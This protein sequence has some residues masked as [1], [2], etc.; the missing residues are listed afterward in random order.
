MKKMLLLFALM[1]LS[2]NTCAP[3]PT[4]TAI[5]TQSPTPTPTPTLT[6]KPTPIPLEEIPAVDLGL[7][8][9]L[10]SLP[11]NIE[12]EILS[13]GML[14][15]L[16]DGFAGAK[17]G[18]I[19]EMLMPAQLWQGAKIKPPL[20]QWVSYGEMRVLWR[21]EVGDEINCVT[22]VAKEDNQWGLEKG[23]ISVLFF[24][25]GENELLEESQPLPILWGVN[26]QVSLTKSDDG[27]SL[28]LKVIGEDGKEDNSIVSIETGPPAEIDGYVQSNA[29]QLKENLI[30]YRDTNGDAV[31]VY[32]TETN[33]AV[34]VIK[35]GVIEFEQKDGGKFEMLNFPNVEDL[36][37]Y[38]GENA[39]WIETTQGQ[40]MMSDYMEYMRYFW[41]GHIEENK[42]LLN[43]LSLLEYP[44][45]N[46]RIMFGMHCPSDIQ[47]NLFIGIDLMS[48]G[49][50]GSWITFKLK[51]NGLME[52]VFVPM[53]AH[54]VEGK[55]NRLSMSDFISE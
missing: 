1:M 17:D 19:C 49:V 10:Y 29:S 39:Q 4:P 35:A 53:K 52:T 11:E 47:T 31:M 50:N 7:K 24:Q 37:H 25:E 42:E 22:V 6:P 9:T 46:P 34:P 16:L 33:E 32:N 12:R 5:P 43:E 13:Q 18:E 14:P 41:Q 36:A 8:G 30:Y 15:V 23:M 20:K 27:K 55:L 28:V 26:D 3:T 45:D 38:L 21:I 48:F 54:A 40:Q 51:E 44:S 2:L